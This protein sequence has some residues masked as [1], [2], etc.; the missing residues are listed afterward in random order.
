MDTSYALTT[1]QNWDTIVF[2][3]VVGSIASSLIPAD[4]IDSPNAEQDDLEMID[5]TTVHTAKSMKMNEEP[6]YE[7]RGG[8]DILE[9]GRL[10]PFQAAPGPCHR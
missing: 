9:I 2:D 10:S 5:S 3:R 4:M 1:S 6:L 7:P 8:D